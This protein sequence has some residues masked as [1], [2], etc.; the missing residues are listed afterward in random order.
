MFRKH[1]EKYWE[2]FNFLLTFQHVSDLCLFARKT[3]NYKEAPWPAGA[4]LPLVIG[5]EQQVVDAPCCG[6]ACLPVEPAAAPAVAA[7]SA[8]DGWKDAAVAQDSCS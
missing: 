5:D 1:W 7:W 3:I 4:I 8:A 6:R 2:K